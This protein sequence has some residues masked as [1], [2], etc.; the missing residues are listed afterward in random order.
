[1]QELILH[2]IHVILIST[3]LAVDK[4]DKRFEP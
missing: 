4:N 3:E 2:L 1:M